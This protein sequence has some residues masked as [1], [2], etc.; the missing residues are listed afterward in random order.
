MGEVLKNG[1]NTILLMKVQ[2]NTLDKCG[3]MTIT[4]Q[5][6]PG[7]VLPTECFYVIDG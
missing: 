2:C 5:S 7:N 4:Q 3:D 1:N 6:F